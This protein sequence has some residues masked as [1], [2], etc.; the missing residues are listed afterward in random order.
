MR[1]A[2]RMRVQR[3]ECA[4]GS[5][6]QYRERGL[7]ERTAEPGQIAVQCEPDL[8]RACTLDRSR[9][10]DASER[11]RALE[12]VVKDAPDAEPGWYLEGQ[13][14]HQ[15]RGDCV[16]RSGAVVEQQTGFVCGVALEREAEMDQQLRV[17]ADAVAKMHFVPHRDLALGADHE[18]SERIVAPGGVTEPVIEDL[19]ERHHRDAMLEGSRR[20]KATRHHEC[21]SPREVRQ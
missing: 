4:P 3:G 15:V 19:D 21:A 16:D 14:P 7:L 13:L 17:A 9:C 6:G 1:H 11:K 5:R 10:L 2:R 8:H 18:A 12:T 20:M